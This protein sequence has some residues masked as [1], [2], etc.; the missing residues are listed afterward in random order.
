LAKRLLLLQSQKKRLN[1]LKRRLKEAKHLLKVKKRK[2]RLAS[3]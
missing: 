3:P 1:L 2:K